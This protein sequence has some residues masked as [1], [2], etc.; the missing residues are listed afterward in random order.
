M[1]VRIVEFFDTR[2]AALEHRGPPD[3]EHDTARRLIGWRIANR[4]S[5]ERHR[6]F[7][8]HDVDVDR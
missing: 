6:T 8:V 7:A 3:A 1:D 2:V 4:L 5:P